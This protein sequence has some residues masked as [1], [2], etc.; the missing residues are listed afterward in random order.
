MIY[1]D[2]AKAFDTVPHVRLINKIANYE[3]TGRISDWVQ[4]FLSWRKQRVVINGKYLIITGKL[5][6]LNSILKN[7]HL[8]S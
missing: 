1:M 3:R 5:Q 6:N 4:N 2:F 8:K 7:Q